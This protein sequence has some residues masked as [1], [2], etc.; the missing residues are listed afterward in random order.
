MLSGEK[1]ERL[2]QVQQAY[3]QGMLS[4]AQVMAWL[5]Q[6]IEIELQKPDEEVDDTWIDACEQYMDLME[7][8][9]QWP[10][11]RQENWA[12]I[13][14]SIKKATYTERFHLNWRIACAAACFI[15]MLLAG[16]SYTV[17]WFQS[18]QSSDEQVYTLAGQQV[19]VGAENAAAASNSTAWHELETTS[20]SEL[21]NF[22]GDTPPVPTWIP[23]GW[24]LSNYYAVVDGN[25]QELTVTYQNADESFLLTY[26]YTQADDVSNLVADFYQ[27]ESGQ[28]VQ[29]DNGW[30]IYITSNVED[31]VAV[32]VT[33]D[34]YIFLAGPVN[35]AEI[36]EIINSIT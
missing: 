8:P 35:L 16:I 34:A 11:H 17:Q 31:T 36:L 13:Q 12:A 23:E 25:R 30:E 20:F 24:Q 26:T 14:A 2:Q 32:W 15:C 29:L 9:S 1:A 28:Y 22:L 18:S 21:C 33:S 19:E 27:D 3:Q 5:M 6:A 7:L 10:N 4:Q